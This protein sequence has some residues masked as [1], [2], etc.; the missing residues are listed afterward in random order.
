MY[1]IPFSPNFRINIPKLRKKGKLKRYY[2]PVG[3]L[4]VSGI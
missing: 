1:N 4:I 2:L 3:K